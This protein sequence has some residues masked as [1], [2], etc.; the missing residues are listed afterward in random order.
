MLAIEQLSFITVQYFKY[1]SRA[2]QREYQLL[3]YIIISLYNDNVQTRFKYSILN[4]AC[5]AKIQLTG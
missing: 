1:L 4:P 3:N 2:V 5:N